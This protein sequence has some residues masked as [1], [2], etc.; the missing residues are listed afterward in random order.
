M[1]GG[2]VSSR[3][4]GYYNGSTWLPFDITFPFQD[5]V[6]AAYS[7]STGELTLGFGVG[8]TACAAAVTAVTNSGT[9]AAYP[10]LTASAPTTAATDAE[11]VMRLTQLINYTSKDAIYFNLTMVAGEVLTLDLRPGQKTFTSSF[12]GNIIDTILPS[13]KLSTWRLLPG[14]NN[15]SIWLTGGSGAA[16][17]S[18]NE[19]FWSIDN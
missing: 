4:N 15:I 3:N 7:A 17:L 13:S 16:K 11:G 10:I 18:F 19:R 14:V 12:R 9:A 1:L 2:L 6:T 5:D 8:G